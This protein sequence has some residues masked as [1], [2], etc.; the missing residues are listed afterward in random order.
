MNW[1]TTS[2]KYNP[3]WNTTSSFGN[4]LIIYNIKK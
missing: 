2:T 1:V 3:K 4:V